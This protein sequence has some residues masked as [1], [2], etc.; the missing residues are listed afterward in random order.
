MPGLVVTIPASLMHSPSTHPFRERLQRARLPQILLIILLWWL[1][2]TLSRQLQ[3]PLPGSIVA[4][5]ALLALLGSRLLPV[6]YLRRGA[7]TLLDNMLLFFVPACMAVIEYPELVG[8]TGLKLLLV[9]VVG[10]I[11]VMAAT[12]L[13][14]EACFR[15]GGRHDA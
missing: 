8:P 12:A 11:M 13:V 4:M 15:R 14:V 9:I 3:L 1:G 7:D 10:T 2:E 6:E 5:A